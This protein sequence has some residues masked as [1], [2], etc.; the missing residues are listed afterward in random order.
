M[1][2]YSDC[3]VILYLMVVGLQAKAGAGQMKQAIT[4][5]CEW[6]RSLS[7][8]PVPDMQYPAVCPSS[9]FR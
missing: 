5:R 8:P 7:S 1:G 2:E 4:W 9:A 3:T 6:W